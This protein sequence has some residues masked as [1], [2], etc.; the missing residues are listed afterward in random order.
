[1]TFPGKIARPTLHAWLNISHFQFHLHIF[2]LRT[3]ASHGSMQ[4]SKKGEFWWGRFCQMSKLFSNFQFS[5]RGGISGVQVSPSLIDATW[6]PLA[7]DDSK[8]SGGRMHERFWRYW[9]RS[10]KVQ[11]VEHT[12]TEKSSSETCACCFFWGVFFGCRGCFFSNFYGEL[13]IIYWVL[14]DLLKESILM[15]S[16]EHQWPDSCFFISLLSKKS[17]FSNQ[18]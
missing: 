1:M 5:L 14:G 16:T 13:W 11:P 10:S 8:T 15:W 2:E 6:I 7:K 3:A 17:G 18:I 9:S 12:E 4:P